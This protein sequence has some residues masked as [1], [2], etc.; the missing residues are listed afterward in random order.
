MVGRR[1][2]ASGGLPRPEAALHQ[3]DSPA[4]GTPERTA[5]Q[6]EKTDLTTTSATKPYQTDTEAARVRKITACHSRSVRNSNAAVRA[7]AARTAVATTT[8]DSRASC[9][10]TT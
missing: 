2:L 5:D 3:D 1:A 6:K 7:A 4:T 8:V 10:G 9:T